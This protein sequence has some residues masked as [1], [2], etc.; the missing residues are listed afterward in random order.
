[1]SL[2]SALLPSRV[3][4]LILAGSGTGA[5]R[6]TH[7]CQDLWAAA[8]HLHNDTGH[9]DGHLP[10]SAVRPL[11]AFVRGKS[12]GLGQSAAARP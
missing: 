4:R 5:R 7:W 9:D 2:P 3:V 11:V 1:M 12:L 8:Y 6:W 10:F